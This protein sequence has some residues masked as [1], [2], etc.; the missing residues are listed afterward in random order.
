M[1]QAEFVEAR[2]AGQD[3]SPEVFHTKLTVGT[4]LTEP[5]RC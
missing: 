2:K 1:P 3:F 5:S 4:P